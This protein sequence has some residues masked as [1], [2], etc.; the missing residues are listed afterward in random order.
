MITCPEHR[1]SYPFC[2]FFSIH[3]QDFRTVR[4]SVKRRRH[5]AKI[6][7]PQSLT[8]DMALVFFPYPVLKDLLDY[9]SSKH[10]I[11]HHIEVLAYQIFTFPANKVEQIDVVA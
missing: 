2:Q 3:S 6:K 4:E 1:R 7:F 9:S 10:L 8:V 5:F 11:I